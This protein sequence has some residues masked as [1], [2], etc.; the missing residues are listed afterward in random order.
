MVILLTGASGFL[1]RH[2]L[3]ALQR[4]SH[5]VIVAGRRP[6]DG[7][8]HVAADFAHD[9]DVGRW[10]PRVRGV[11]VVVNAVGILRE[12]GSQTFANVHTR[13]P[14]AL[15]AACESSGVRRVIQI[16]ALGAQTGH[17]GY[18]RSK[19]AA[20]TTLAATSLQW[21]IVQP[22][23]VYGPGGTSARLF[24]TLASL[25]LIPLPGGG[26]Q[27]LQPVHVDDLIAALVVL[28]ET[29]AFSRCRVA[30]VGPRPVALRA[31][32]SELRSALGL[33]RAR[34]VPV[35]APLARL[36]ARLASL[37]SRSLLDSE[38]LGMLEAGNV[39]DAAPTI[40]LL[41]RPPQEIAAFIPRTQG[42]ALR[43]EA[44]LTW[45]LPLLKLSL[46]FVWVWTAVASLWLYPR[47][48]SYELLARTG[49]PAALQSLFLYGAIALDFGF[50]IATLALRGQR[51]LWAGQ[52]ILIALYTIVITV[53]LPEFW[54][55]PYGPLSKNLPMLAVLCMLYVLEEK[56]WNTSS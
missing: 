31:L 38:S 12:R 15:F 42:R 5:R 54:F 22:S 41:G 30:I 3:D 50:G 21:T 1:G 33:T 29:D 20:D 40:R 11:D 23:V 18:F 28:C 44:Q 45:L 52:M 2:L 43:R 53:R 49:V 17:S 47:E 36:G 4:R 51:M 27:Q 24:T 16:S 13:A 32:L 8:E 7:H 34:I 56:R 25:P 39:A 46:A 35:P 19:H 6:I 14:Q 37:S 48:A 10:L 55:H 26:H 9:C